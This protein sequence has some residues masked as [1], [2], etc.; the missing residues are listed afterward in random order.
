MIDTPF[1]CVTVKLHLLIV[2]RAGACLLFL[3]IC[4]DVELRILFLPALT[5]ARLVDRGEGKEEVTII[6][7]VPQLVYL[8]LV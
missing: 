5:C 7:S 8:L 3:L 1:Y 2:E 6:I 4:C